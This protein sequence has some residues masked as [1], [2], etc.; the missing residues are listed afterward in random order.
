MKSW[1]TQSGYEI[2]RLLSGRS[3]VF[4]VIANNKSI[5]VDTGPGSYWR[6]LDKR[7]EQL[8]IGRIDML[9]LTHAHYDHASNSRR[10]KEKY[11]A[12]VYIQQQEAENLLNGENPEIHGTNVLTMLMTSLLGK[13]FLKMKRYIG[14]SAYVIVHDRYDF[15]GVGIHAYLIHTPGHSK[16]SISLIVDDEIAIIGDCMFGVKKSSVYPPFADNSHELISSWGKLIETGCTLFL[17]SHGK[18][19]TRDQLIEEFNR[20][21]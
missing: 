21:K 9:V 13:T 5:L 16:G 20:R 12:I 1:K 6:K 15:E 19:K 10:V 2:K 14:C 3:N 18:E 17:P 4:L 8:G 11:G 7:I